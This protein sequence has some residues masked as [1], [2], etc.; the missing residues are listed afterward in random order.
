MISNAPLGIIDTLS[1]GFVIVNKRLWIVL[2]PILLDV[3][4]L[5][6]P[7]VSVSPLVDEAAAF[8]QSQ[9]T[10]QASRNNAAEQE[11]ADF[12]QALEQSQE[13]L[14]SYR[15]MNLLA[16]LAWQLPSVVAATSSGSLPRYNGQPMA[17][18]T[19]MPAFLL[20]ALAL[21]VLGLLLASVY[22]AAIAQALTNDVFS[23]HIL[24]RRAFFGWLS[25]VLFFGTLCVMAVTLGGGLIVALG[26]ASLLG[27]GLMAFTGSVSFALV[28]TASLYLFFV[29]DA[30]FVL[31][32]WPF[33]AAF[34]SV[35]V[36]WR[37]FWSS[38]GFVLLVSLILTGMVIIWN[39]IVKNPL[40]L[41]PAIVGHAY[42]ATGFS[43][44]GMLFFSQRFAHLQREVAA[45]RMSS[46]S[47]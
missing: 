12:S 26:F 11:G 9:V 18:V 34:Y 24:L 4:L 23:P 27:P 5:F 3:F 32:S 46:R 42:I 7:G 36:V 6:G 1:T 14:T 30:I 19:T 20:S 33:R 47:R 39:F 41:A 31:E 28:L 10:A 29:D 43:A 35:A 15:D 25:F 17:E 38:L 37:N 21:G 45:M 13:M 16:V 44:A 8:M 2:L 22:L 40:G